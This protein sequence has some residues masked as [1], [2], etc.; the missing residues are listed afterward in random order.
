MKA[1]AEW[2]SLT[3]K[4]DG[5]DE[6]YKHVRVVAFVATIDDVPEQPKSQQVAQ[7]SLRPQACDLFLLCCLRA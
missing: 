3:A 6:A 1:D 5:R 2:E 4:V 7:A